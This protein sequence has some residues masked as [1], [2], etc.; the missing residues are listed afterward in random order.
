MRKRKKLKEL[1]LKDNFL[2]G[3]VMMEEENCKRFLE[4]ILFSAIEKI[5]IIREKS[6][7][8]H[9]EYKGIRLDVFAKDENNTHYNVEIQVLNTGYLEKRSRYY[10]SHMDMEMLA[11][12]HGYEELPRVYVIF[13]CD[14]DPFGR[15][16]YC[17]TF[18]NCCVED[19]GL[20]L[21]DGCTSIF[22]STC[23]ENKD[24]VSDEL[25]KFLAFVNADLEDS[26]RDFNDTFVSQLQESIRKIK[27]NRR[28][29]ERYMVLEELL[30][31]EFSEGKAEGKAE[32]VIE[33]LE[34]VG[35]VPE[36]LKK[37]IM[38]QNN[39]QILKQ[40]IKLAVSAES[41]EKFSRLI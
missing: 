17:Y 12:G 23:G 35:T 18:K 3:A 21:E 19:E 41:I 9:P 37:K 38:N 27:G 39:L 8:Y 25:A 32:T 20:S 15:K 4:M 11:T 13:V 22:L 33:I 16:K 26:M 10:H 14:F 1:T 5:E 28:M 36:D 34:E 7:L 30:Q 2:F 40:W 6:I 24:E 29:E 31:Y